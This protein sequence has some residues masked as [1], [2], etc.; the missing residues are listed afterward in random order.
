MANA[1]LVRFGAMQP[2][3]IQSR[4]EWWLLLTSMFVHVGFL[5]ILFNSIALYSVGTLVERVFGHARFA[6]VYF[7][8]GLFASLSSFAYFI[9][10]SH[11]M[12]VVAA[13]ASGAIFGILGAVIV[14]GV[15]RRSIVPRAIAIQMSVFV[16]VIT[17]LNLA[18]DTVTPQIDYRA[19]VGG[20]VMGLVLGYVLA[21]RVP[22]QSVRHSPSLAS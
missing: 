8:S 13:G 17:V 4:H 14:L 1:T 12:Y 21:P 11:Q 19:H 3:L 5:H 15:L 16:A 9:W 20:L 22:V 18:F 6:L 7:A 10:V 2:H